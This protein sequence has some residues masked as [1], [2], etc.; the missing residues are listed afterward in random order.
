[1]NGWPKDLGW[2]GN[3]EKVCWNSKD[4]EVVMSIIYN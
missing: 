3:L 4:Q 2:M 1:M